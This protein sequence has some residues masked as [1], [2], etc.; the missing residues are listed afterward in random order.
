[1]NDPPL[2][3]IVPP[4]E[5]AHLLNLKQ[6]Y[7]AEIQHS[8]A[9]EFIEVYHNMH[10]YLRCNYAFGFFNG[11][12]LLG[13]DCYS[14]GPHP[15]FGKNMSKGLFGNREV[16]LANQGCVCPGAPPNAMGVMTAK[17]I[18][19]IK[20]NF[21]EVKL[22]VS[23]VV[24]S[25]GEVGGFLKGTNWVYIGT[26]DFAAGR[27]VHRYIYPLVHHKKP[28]LDKWANHIQPYPVREESGST[29]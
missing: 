7:I 26:S 15:N 4:E 11:N 29:S 17:S 22:L 24:A 19:Y 16:W 27:V 10:E 25:Q 14:L 18:K 23:W 9:R 5:A 21:P 6:A 12:F 20:Q 1:M 2:I 13:V 3:Y 28:I 8:K